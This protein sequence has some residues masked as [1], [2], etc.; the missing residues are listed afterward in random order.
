MRADGFRSRHFAFR[1][2]ELS[3]LRR[4]MVKAAIV[5]P[6]FTVDTDEKLRGLDSYI[7]SSNFQV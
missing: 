1:G 3:L 6:F 2:A 7:L 4:I 5:L